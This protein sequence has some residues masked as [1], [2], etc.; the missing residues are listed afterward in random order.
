MKLSSIFFIQQKRCTVLFIE[1]K[2]T[3]L[4]E[5]FFYIRNNW[6]G[7]LRQSN[8]YLIRAEYEFKKFEYLDIRTW[9]ADSGLHLKC[10][11]LAHF[12][13]LQH[14]PYY[15]ILKEKNIKCGRWSI[16]KNPQLRCRFNTNK[17][18]C[19]LRWYADVFNSASGQRYETIGVVSINRSDILILSK[20]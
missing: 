2:S 18:K 7:V 4:Q 20:T 19:E 16:N 13:Q 1:P 17:L 5:F 8:S 12:L 6:G 14:T 11:Y 10:G 15:T 3:Y 9:D